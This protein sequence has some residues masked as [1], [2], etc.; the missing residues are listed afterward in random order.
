M[1]LRYLVG[2]DGSGP[3][4]AAL[5]WVVARAHRLPAPIVLVNV[6]EGDAGDMGRAFEERAARKGAMIV[7]RRLHALRRSEPGLVIEGLALEGS[8]PW[9]L[10]RTA[11]PDDMIVIGTHKTGFLHGRVLGSRS[12]Q[13]VV[14]APCSVAVVPEADLRFRS[15]VVAGIDR[16][17]TAA[18]VARFAADE[19]ASREEELLLLEA[20]LLDTPVQER[21]PLAVAM[22]AARER[23]PS[24]VIRTRQST[25]GAAEALLD[26]ARDKALLVLGPGSQDPDRSP[27]GSV[28]HS[29][30]LNVNAPVIVARPV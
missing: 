4:D 22:V 9:E 6:T 13:I 21:A 25:R 26:A 28:L 23:R 29:V 7:S 11:H 2:F 24:L 10:A 14:A 27:I 17:A 20:D 30:L 18:S 3:S 19:A 8:V 5:A 16:V 15:G 1:T 12:V